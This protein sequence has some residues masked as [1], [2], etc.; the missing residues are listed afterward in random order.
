MGVGISVKRVPNDWYMV[1]ER[2]FTQKI[3]VSNVGTLRSLALLNLS[4]RM[5]DIYLALKRD[6]EA[7]NDQSVKKASV[8]SCSQ[9]VFET[10]ASVVV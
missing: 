8:A 7:E 1:V 3:S 2:P 10:E 5:A 6:T 9:C 4:D